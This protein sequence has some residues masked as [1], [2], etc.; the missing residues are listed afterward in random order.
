MAL[1]V[2]VVA[3]RCGPDCGNMPAHPVPFEPAEAPSSSRRLADGR[4]VGRHRLAGGGDLIQPM[5]ALRPHEADLLLRGS[6]L[7]AGP[8]RRGCNRGS[9]LG[10]AVHAEQE[11]IKVASGRLRASASGLNAAMRQ[12]GQRCLASLP[13]HRR[14]R[15]TA[16]LPSSS[17]RRSRHSHVRRL[18]SANPTPALRQNRSARIPKA[19]RLMALQWTLPAI[20]GSQSLA[21]C[22]STNTGR[23]AQSC[24]RSSCLSAA[25]HPW[26]LAAR[27]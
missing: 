19:K 25:R 27:T 24:L 11:T 16:C 5:V 14:D 22:A 18:T 21:A 13:R 3:C 1:P 6:H 17:S 4:L 26:H 2:S 15:P 10:L 12:R 7:S 8:R 9:L 20:A 23:M